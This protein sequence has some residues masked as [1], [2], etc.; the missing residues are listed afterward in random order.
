VSTVVVRFI[1]SEDV[2]RLVPKTKCSGGPAG[3]HTREYWDAYS[4]RGLQAHND[5]EFGPCYRKR[6]G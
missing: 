6:R 5:H 1:P 2:Q 4:G 3:R